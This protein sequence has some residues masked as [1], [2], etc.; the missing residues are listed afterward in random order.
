MFDAISGKFQDVFRKLTGNA[1]LS[2]DNVKDAA[3]AIKRALLEADVNLTIAK[4]FVADVREKALGEKVLQGVNP[5]QQFIKV[6]N[7]EL[8][9]MMS[10]PNSVEADGSMRLNWRKR[11]PTVFLMAGLQGA[12]KTTTCAKLARLFNTKH[13]KR[14]LMVAADL[15]RPAAVEQLKVLGK[16]IGVDVY[17]EE[18]SN[19]RNVCENALKKA[20]DEDY[21]VLILD[22][23]GRL[24]VDDDLMREVSDIAKLTSPD[25]T[26][27]VCDAMTGQDAVRSAKAFDEQLPLTG[28]ILTKTDGDARGGA[29][30]TVRKVTGKPIK[31]VGVGERVEQLEHFF[32]ERMASCILGMGDVVSL[33]EKAQ[34]VIDEREAIKMEEKLLKDEF[35]LDDF[36]DQIEAIQKMG[37]LKDLVKMIPGA[38]NLPLD[39][40]N[41]RSMLHLKAM[42]QSMTPRER[43]FPDQLAKE[44]RRKVRISKGAGRPV[45]EL[46]RLLKSFEQMRG[47]IRGLADSG[48]MGRMASGHFKRQK[49]KKVK[50]QLKANKKGKGQ[51]PG[52]T[53]QGEAIRAAMRQQSAGMPPP[54]K[55]EMDAFKKKFNI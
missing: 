12:G 9:A 36:L 45:E 6:V 23:A 20:K 26:L 2:E 13:K 44:N 54:S 3:R 11:G 35:T 19:P 40:F 18:N 32:A 38:N 5:A 50:K 27:L 46:N 21:D 14:C 30:L 24:H 4:D 7:D 41:E 39:A 15:Q 49:A 8:I 17:F 52:H 55:E 10:D 37:P 16:Q 48:L 25:E 42:I 43:R 47:M 33:V 28:V 51:M 53:K 22:T 1:E 34:S 31:F 29:A